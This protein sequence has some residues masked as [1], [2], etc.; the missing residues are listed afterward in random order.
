MAAG[1]RFYE[2]KIDGVPGA[3]KSGFEND[4]QLISL[5]DVAVD[6]IDGIRRRAEVDAQSLHVAMRATGHFGAKV[7]IE[8]DE[9]A[10]G[11]DALPVVRL[12]MDE[13]PVYKILKYDLALEGDSQ[14][15][16][17]STALASA[18]EIIAKEAPEL[19]GQD[20]LVS[21]VLGLE[22]QVMQ[23]LVQHGYPVP[24]ARQR[25]LR[26]D[27]KKAGI[28]VDI[29]IDTGPYVHFGDTSFS[30]L[31]RVKERFLKRRIAWKEGEVFDVKKVEST[32]KA[33]MATGVVSA[34]EIIYD[35]RGAAYM[36]VDILIYEAK[37]RSI[38]AGGEYST[39]QG[40]RANVFWEH[41]NVFG[42]AE[43]F[44]VSVEGGLDNREVSFAFSKPDMFGTKAISLRNTLKVVDSNL[45]AYKKRAVTSVNMLSW[46]I[47]PHL[48]VAGGLG[49]EQ[50]QITPKGGGKKGNFTLLS[51]PMTAWF[52]NT[53]SALDA[54]KGVRA[55]V[56][57]TPYQALN[58]GV[59]FSL[60]DV[61]ASHYLGV[62]SSLVWANRARFAMIAGGTLDDI[63][64]D[65]RLYSGGSGSVRGYGYQKLGPIG[66]NGK[67]SG[68]KALLELASEIRYDLTPT[69]GV[70]G[71]VE[72][73]RLSKTVSGSGDILW[74]TGV[75]VRYRT[76]AG[77]IRFDV[78][79]P[80]NKRRGEDAYQIY[81]G[82][83]QAF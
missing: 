31:K 9:P 2:V 75:G 63:P 6:G 4:S 8:I 25:I 82:L 18:R 55:A 76:I 52:D 10:Q 59:S 41:R 79:V 61:S 50:S 39:S 24:D 12:I 64:A 21:H 5:E 47:T 16:G 19:L 3:V 45:E 38:G 60:F 69:I 81:M 34:L 65:K 11:T 80:I 74:G 78:A 49:L 28:D 29:I 46:R 53:N 58:K 51:V 15:T 48:E 1:A 72:G 66:E 54:T 43:K 57:V 73:G 23:D 70:V 67:P 77:P 71:F 32:R 42:A 30:G 13:G 37:M 40:V 83:G 27:H 17:A 35:P 14:R 20:A 62:S 44:R 26:V 22:K 33:L 7:T 56:G 36:P 68:G